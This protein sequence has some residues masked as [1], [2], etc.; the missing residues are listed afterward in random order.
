MIRALLQ[1]ELSDS[2][3][4]LDVLQPWAQGEPVSDEAFES[5][6]DFMDRFTQAV[7]AAGLDALAE[8]LGLVRLLLAQCHADPARENVAAERKH[9]AGWQRATGL[10]LEGPGSAH[11]VEAMEYSLVASTT[12][13]DL[14]WQ[15]ELIERLLAAPQLPDASDATA[16]PDVADDARE[17]T[18]DV[19]TVEPDQLQVFLFD[20]PRLA[21]DI[22]T[23]ISAW[24][25]GNC[26]VAQMQSAMRAA[27]TLKGS[28]Y[29]LGLRG[30]GRLSH[31]L[32]DVL[33][34]GAEDVQHGLSPP[35]AL[36]DILLHAVDMLQQIVGFLQG[37]EAEPSGVHRMGDALRVAARW[38]H[39]DRTA[40]LPFSQHAANP[41][42][43]AL[44][45]TAPTAHHRTS[46][47]NAA[48]QVA[49][50]TAS[51]S[52]LPRETSLIQAPAVAQ[53]APPAQQAPLQLDAA[54]MDLL[55]RR[56][57][58][59]ISHNA[60]LLDLA[61]GADGWLQALT[62][63]NRALLDSITD[64]TQLVKHQSFQAQETMRARDEF[65]LLELD[66]YDA[67]QNTVLSMEEK[68]RDQQ[69]FLAQLSA[70][71]A[72]LENHLREGG[73]TLAAQRQDLLT[74]RATTVKTV[75][76]RLRRIVTQTAEATGR[77]VQFMLHGDDVQIDGL[78]LQ[79][80]VEAL[81]HVLRN[82]VDHGI[83]PA[84]ERLT[85]GK[86]QAGVVEVRFTRNADRVT[87]TVRDDGR[88]LDRATIRQTAIANG[89]LGEDSVIDEQALFN[90]ILLP[91][92]STREHVTETSGRGVGMDVVNDRLLQLQGEL[93]IHSVSGQGCTFRMTV[94]ANSG[95]VHAVLMA[96]GEGLFAVPSDVID[97]I[98]P[99]S[100]ASYSVT[101]NGE[102]QLHY[103]DQAIPA[104]VLADWLQIES[105]VPADRRTPVIVRILGR[106]MALLADAVLDA[107]EL[108]VQS[109]GRLVRRVGGL[110]S[111]ALT[112]D[113]RAIF[114]LDLQALQR[115]TGRASNR[116]GTGR[117]QQRARI[118]P[119]RI[120]V[121]D[122][123]WAVRMTM[124]QLLEDA[125]YR[126]DTA[127][128]GN[129]A[130][131]TLRQS[132]PDLVITD[133]EMPELNGL[134]LA[135]R[136][137]D[138]PDWAG[139]PRIM[140][141]SRSADKHRQA[142]MEAGIGLYLTKPYRDPDLLAHVRAMLASKAYA[143]TPAMHTV[144]AAQS[145]PAVQEA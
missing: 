140:L 86:P 41:D 17:Y 122:D 25:S 20:A 121:V 9:L 54:H 66:R 111:A 89:L 56:S 43:E 105:D 75:A 87:V 68:V 131:D 80:L 10:Y 67:L 72:Q 70:V 23:A 118:A 134:E 141:T 53:A 94:Q 104:S 145:A 83:E 18:L 88:G 65:D 108:I 47:Q 120:L 84:A 29:I 112:P 21:L 13:V 11:A 128:N 34:C 115:G 46:T 117:M 73:S 37:L 58:Q 98:I 113:G 64:L 59:S 137:R 126:V 96:C 81:L 110:S 139:I 28:G 31:H 135:R 71:S 33:E 100:E 125:G 51:T 26:T 99:A 74:V 39:S 102:T 93:Q 114:M 136:M 8:Y 6:L 52:P 15:E 138:F 42:V 69:E 130:L 90:L 50:S 132:P 40:V 24:G 76:S 107:R 14:A 62:T 61:H 27:H 77:T 19:S 32:E 7:Q 129:A 36:L 35:A 2:A 3:S 82:A 22:E 55:L 48:P 12:T 142:A 123:A 119:A 44:T 4:T 30:V 49:N 79:K 57:G 124:K 60:R 95:V 5:A 1:Q 133:L 144:P 116:Q 109:V 38:L 85:A 91:G 97:S 101:A 16:E 127:H 106:P 143:D 78:V 63:G 103:A 45:D 92:F